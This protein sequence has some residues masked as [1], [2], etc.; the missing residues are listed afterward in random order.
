[1][2][3]G[4][5]LEKNIFALVLFCPFCFLLYHAKEGAHSRDQTVQRSPP[6]IATVAP[7]GVLAACVSVC[8]RAIV[9]SLKTVAEYENVEGRRTTTHRA[10]CEALSALEMLAD[11]VPSLTPRPDDTHGRL[12]QIPVT[13][14]YGTSAVNE[15]YLY[16]TVLVC[17][18][19]KALRR[20]THSNY[21]QVTSCLPFL[22][23]RSPDG[24]THK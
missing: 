8:P 15:K 4:L 23:K 10:T 7:S 21:L 19:H 16:S 5:C 9:N 3:L 6:I 22:R 24:A 18:T 20:E 11:D 1:M 12:S 17:H 14:R 2:H 13:R